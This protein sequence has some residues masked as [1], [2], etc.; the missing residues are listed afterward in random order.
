VTWPQV[1]R[2]TRDEVHRFDDPRL[3]YSVTY[4]SPA[5]LAATVYVYTGGVAAIP[6]GASE[7]ARAEL[8]KATA[9]VMEA[10]RRGVWTSVDG[11]QPREERFGT[12][13]RPLAVWAASFRLGHAEGEA[14]SDLYV[15]GRRG[16]FVKIRC[17]YLS[18][19]KVECE[20]DRARLL[21][22]LA[23]ALSP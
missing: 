11:G 1:E 2:F 18:E 16:E 21:D 8:A 13:P 23:A 5:G 17:T 15:T 12:G 19:R 9:D 10:K 3:G 6:D 4:R 14:I 20:R 22:A 7:V